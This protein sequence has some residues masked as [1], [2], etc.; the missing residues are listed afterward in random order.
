[1]NRETNAPTNELLAD[2]FSTEYFWLPVAQV[3]IQSWSLVNW[4]FQPLLAV[5]ASARSAVI[6]LWA[7]VTPPRAMAPETSSATGFTTERGT[8]FRAVAKERADEC[9][10]LL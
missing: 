5:M 6:Q 3:V 8:R 10:E 1:M 2:G 4:P 7:R 9:F